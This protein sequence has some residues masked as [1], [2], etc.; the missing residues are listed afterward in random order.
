[1]TGR[2]M[3]RDIISE[4]EAQLAASFY[5]SDVMPLET[6]ARI[7]VG[8]RR[9]K[10]DPDQ[11][12]D[13]AGNGRISF[14]V[15]RDTLAHKLECG[16][17]LTERE[18][19][20]IADYLLERIESPAAPSGRPRMIDAEF[21]IGTAVQWLVKFYD[22]NA[23]RNDSPAADKYGSACDAVAAAM[24]SLKRV[25]NTYEAV[26]KTWFRYKRKV[27]EGKKLRE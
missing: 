14:L 8:L 3:K 7:N 22:V 5:Q 24:V 9:L 25:P 21:A 11:L 12:L 2:K 19:H 18:R 13:D 17:Q 10:L 1:M 27:D 23:T 26:K 16:M 15:L 20:W 4:A 6:S